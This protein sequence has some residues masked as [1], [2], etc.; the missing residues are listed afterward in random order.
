MRNMCMNARTCISEAKERRNMHTIACTHI[1]G[2]GGGCGPVLAFVGFVGLCWLSLAC[3]AVM[4]PCLAGC[5]SIGGLK[6]MAGG[7]RWSKHVAGG[8]KH[9]EVWVG[10]WWL[11][12]MSGGGAQDTWWGLK[13]HGWG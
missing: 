8:L 2:P 11:V 7:C 5:E 1:S 4:G 12:K 9:V 3:M 10:G 13:R 6:C